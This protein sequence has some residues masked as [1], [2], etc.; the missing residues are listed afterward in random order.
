MERF[1][2]LSDGQIIDT[3]VV[4]MNIDSRKMQIDTAKARFSLL[5]FGFKEECCRVFGKTNFE[6][7]P[8]KIL[9]IFEVLNFIKVSFED[10][11]AMEEVRKLALVS[12]MTDGDI[13][14]E[15]IRPIK[16]DLIH[17]V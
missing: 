11:S 10:E 15:L 1:I 5:L 16:S 13:E 3:S 8:L 12:S 2:H 7:C 4:S 6:E 9:A 14:L 17:P